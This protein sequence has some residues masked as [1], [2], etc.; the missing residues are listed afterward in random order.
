MKDEK[1]NTL[2]RQF[3]MVKAPIRELMLKMYVDKC[4][5]LHAIAFL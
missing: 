3:M 5:H 2:L 1:A 4:K